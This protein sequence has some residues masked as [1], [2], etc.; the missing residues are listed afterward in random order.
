MASGEKDWT[1]KK[2]AAVLRPYKE[3]RVDDLCGR[4][5]EREC[6]WGCRGGGREG[7]A[8]QKRGRQGRGDGR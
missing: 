3:I 1:I 5:C 7:G 6:R 2:G 4:A 8:C